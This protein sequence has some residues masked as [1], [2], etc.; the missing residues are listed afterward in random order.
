M[1]PRTIMLA[2]AIASIAGFLYLTIYAAADRGFTIL[3]VVSVLIVLLLGIG[4]V[5]A[6]LEQPHDDE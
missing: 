2:V 6:L 1:R 3:T 4:I 5:G